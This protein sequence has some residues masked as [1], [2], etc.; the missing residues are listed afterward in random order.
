MFLLPVAGGKGGVGKSL[1]AA[2]LAVTLAES[3]YRVVLADL[4]LGGSNLHTI[5]GMRG[6]M[7]GIGSWL[8]SGSADFDEIVLPTRFDNLEFIPGDG[9]IPGLANLPT[10]RKNKLIR[11]LKS[12]D[13]DYLV[14]D[15]GSGSSYNTLDF[16]L[17]SSHGIIVTVPDLTAIL[18][19]YL[20]LKNSVFR[21]LL[22]SFPKGSPALEKLRA[23]QKDPGTLQRLHIPTLVE[24]LSRSDGEGV[25]RFAGE[26][27][28]FHPS[29]VLNMVDDPRQCGKAEK[30]RL[31]CR[32]F[33][34]V[35][36]DHLGVIYRD[37]VQESALHSGIPVAAYKPD[38]TIS[39]GIRR[40]AGKIVDR[41]DKG[42]D[43]GLNL[44]PVD[45]SYRVAE[46]EAEMDFETKLQ[47]VHDLLHSGALSDSDL[48]ETIRSQQQEIHRLRKA[49]RL[50]KS[51]I[52]AAS[53]AGYHVR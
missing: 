11:R 30:I 19:A 27:R 15:L 28:R 47:S 10:A 5:L 23:I 16:F 41:N 13:T 44:D 52:L 1:V 46:L 40:I 18:N 36:A 37:V 29:I 25:A 39:Q 31:S 2:N 17:V 32:R 38:S 9:E 48:L 20:F 24:E 7:R 35:D 33:L 3:G 14:L 4:D 8:T 50:L 6:L 26:L 45:E 34:G 53:E 12:T 42:Y 21:I 51:R 49:N 43:E 22:R